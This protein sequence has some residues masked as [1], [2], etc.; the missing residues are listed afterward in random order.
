MA[1]SH[2]CHLRPAA[3]ADLEAIWRQGAETWAPDQADRSADGFFALFDLLAEF[4]GMARERTEFTP[5]VR[6]HPSSAHL[7]VYRQD[8][9]GI[10]IIR[11]LHARQDLAELL[12]E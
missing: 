6:I 3:R 5:C 7:I 4:P 1:N 9:Q 11:I 12:H 8:G 2:A 10:E